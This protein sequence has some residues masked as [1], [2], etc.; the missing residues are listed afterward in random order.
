MEASGDATSTTPWH[1]F[2]PGPHDTAHVLAWHFTSPPHALW[3]L[4]EMLQAVPVQLV[5]PLHAFVPLQSMAQAV[6]V[7]A[8]FPRHEFCPEQATM[9]P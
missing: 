8:T 4:Q 6:A 9:Q 2:V 1:A 7:H 5:L 3:A